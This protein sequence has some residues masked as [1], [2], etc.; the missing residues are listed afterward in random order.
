MSYK[1]LSVKTTQEHDLEQWSNR[2]LE[3]EI[4]SFNGRTVARIFD[5]YLNGSNLNILEGGC[6]FGAWCEWFQQKG[7]DVVGIEYDRNI[8]ENAKKF[9]P[10]VAVELGDITNLQYP[11]NHFD[12]YISLGV[13]EH[14]EHGPE[15][16]LQEAYRILKPNGLAFV[17]TPYLTV[18][19]K[20]I[21]HP[22]RSLYFLIRKLRGQSSH[23]WE[24]R[25]TQEEL[26]TFLEK[27]GFEIIHKDIDDYEPYVN[28]RHI[29]LWADWY[30]L[31]KKNGEIWELNTLGKFILAI[32]KIFPASW[33]CSGL[34]LV[35]RAVKD[36]SN[37]SHNSNTLNQN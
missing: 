6:G 18:F 8:V 25:F 2:S 10:N 19:R 9:K 13:I 4:N 20:F 32:F 11:D 3:G 14:F 7:Y 1:L 17:T 28:N 23:F 26:Q 34:H 24:Y 37:H 36:D 21:S 31:R 27:A 29:G 12:V 16:A 30:F 33:Y 22:V 5:E 35:A 15:K